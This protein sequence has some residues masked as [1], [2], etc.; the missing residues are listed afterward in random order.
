MATLNKKAAA[1]IVIFALLLWGLMLALIGYFNGNQA[2]VTW[3][4]DEHKEAILENRIDGNNL[5]CWK[6]RNRSDITLVL[7]EDQCQEIAG[8]TVKCF[9]MEQLKDLKWVRK[10]FRSFNKMLIV[11]GGTDFEDNLNAAAYL[12][13]YGY[14]TRM[15]SGGI[16]VVMNAAE[17]AEQSGRPA[18]STEVESVAKPIVQ[19]AES[20]EAN[21]E[22][23]T[24]EE[25]C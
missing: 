13:H 12:S 3:H 7:Q 2:A 22:M 14:D 6:S 5:N 19:P 11:G 1:R 16:E 10:N 8:F 4:I 17:P 20:A 24:E 23:M 21:E 15:L 18:S 9:N 25:G